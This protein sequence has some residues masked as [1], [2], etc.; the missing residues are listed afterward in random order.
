MAVFLGRLKQ[1]KYRLE[2]AGKK[3]DN[4]QMLMNIPPEYAN[5]AQQLYLL[6]DDGFSPENVKKN[7]IS[8]YNRLEYE[9][10]NEAGPSYN[11]TDSN[12]MLSRKK[13]VP[14]NF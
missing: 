14:K 12:L 1:A 2:A 9:N 4:D 6:D 5:I 8:E 11:E 3:I 13:K 10:L 7:L